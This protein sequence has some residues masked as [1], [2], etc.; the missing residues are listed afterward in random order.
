MLDEWEWAVDPEVGQLPVLYI[1]EILWNFE[2]II[3][4]MVYKNTSS[5]RIYYMIQ[6]INC[7]GGYK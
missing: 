5:V 4:L 3:G 1:R 2:Y 6:N 7:H